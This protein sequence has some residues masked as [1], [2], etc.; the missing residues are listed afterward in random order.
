MGD[1]IEETHRLDGNGI[2]EFAGDLRRPGAI[3]CMGMERKTRRI[4][5]CPQNDGGC[6]GAAAP[7]RGGGGS[8]RL[9]FFVLLTERKER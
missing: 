6:S 7:W 3:P 9:F 4:F 5:R 1:G 2:G 8:V